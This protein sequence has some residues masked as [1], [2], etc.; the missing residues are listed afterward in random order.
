MSLYLSPKKL[1]VEIVVSKALGSLTPT[2]E[3]MLILLADRTIKKFKYYN[4]DDRFDCYQ[5]GLYD[6]FKNWYLFNE[7]KSE[8][9]FAYLTEIFKRGATQGLNQI[10]KRKGIVDKS[11]KVY[12]ID[13]IND[14][15]GMH[16]I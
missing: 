14:G 13:S 10:H 15:Q 1:Y 5:Q 11:I 8:N 2:A 12:S 4:P 6:L 7:E 3:G 16:N 9:V